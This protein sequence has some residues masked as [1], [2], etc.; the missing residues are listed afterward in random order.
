MSDYLKSERWP[1]CRLLL[2]Y[3]ESLSDEQIDPTA[4]RKSLRAESP[5]Q[6]SA[7]GG[8]CTRLATRQMERAKS[9]DE[10]VAAAQQAVSR[11]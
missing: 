6:A 4:L 9:P 8:G 7:I 11:S 2:A 1:S 10:T 5:L 3:D